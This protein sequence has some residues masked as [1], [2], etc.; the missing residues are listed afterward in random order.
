M[1][2]DHRWARRLEA[3]RGYLM[4]E[5]PDRALAELR[6]IGDALDF[7]FEVQRLTGEALR[8]KGAHEAALAAF[9]RADAEQPDDLS[10]LMG[11]AWCFKRTD[12]LPQAIECMERAYRASPDEPIVL[13]NLACYHALAGDKPQ[14]L[15]WLGRAIRMDR[16]LR[17]L[18]PEERDFDRLRHDPDFQFIVEAGKGNEE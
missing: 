9:L 1:S 11:M 4:L 18:I 5:I 2:I 7:R 8:Q 13:Y 14:A 6:G 17:K 16:S 3:A 15:S 12:R 10:V